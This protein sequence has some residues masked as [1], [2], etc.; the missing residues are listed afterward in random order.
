MLLTDVLSRLRY[1]WFLVALMVLVVEASPAFGAEGQGM[2]STRASYGLRC[3]SCHG[4]SGKGDGWRAKLSWLKMPNFSDS[5][6]M[7]K[8][9]DDD[10]LLAIK[11]GR[12]SIMPAFGL[13]MT[14]RELKDMVAHIR[15]FDKAPEPPKP[16]GTA[17]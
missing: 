14:D 2:S 17:H 6:Y 10:F 7:Q 3:A 4:G 5:A 8:R 9:S 15:S 11:Q 16:A 13:E 1:Q 12:K